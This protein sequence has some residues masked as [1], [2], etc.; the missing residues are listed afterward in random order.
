MAEQSRKKPPTL[1]YPYE[2]AVTLNAAIDPIGIATYETKAA[3]NAAEIG[4]AHV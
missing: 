3:A 4:R 2:L 1:P